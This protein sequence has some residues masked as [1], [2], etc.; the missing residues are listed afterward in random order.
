LPQRALEHRKR[1]D[2]PHPEHERPADEVAN[3]ALE[4][5]LERR[6]A[7]LHL[8]PQL[9]DIRPK[10]RDVAHAGVHLMHPANVRSANPKINFVPTG[11]RKC[12]AERVTRIPV[13][14]GPLPGAH[15]GWAN[16][17]RTRTT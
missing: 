14:R 13:R 15:A 6:E 9:G 2:P 3:A 7:H 17:T 4:T 5:G 12:A 8:V 16:A 1:D 11:P 10:R